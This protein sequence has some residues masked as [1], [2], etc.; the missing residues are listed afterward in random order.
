[1]RM[2]AATARMPLMSLW[3]RVRPRDWGWDVPVP[4]PAAIAASARPSGGAGSFGDGLDD[5]ENDPSAGSSSGD[6][7]DADPS[8]ESDASS[9]ATFDPPRLL[10]PWRW[11]WPPCD[12][13]PE[14]VEL[15]VLDA[16]L[17]PE[18][19]FLWW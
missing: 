15:D 10:R 4:T 17:V 3:E 1:M 12:R 8:G 18:L 2:R 6:A 16:L 11:R 19:F 5:G 7:V 9:G 13:D 14:D